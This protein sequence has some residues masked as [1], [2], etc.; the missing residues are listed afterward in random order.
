MDKYNVENQNLLK[1]P[2]ILSY[3]Y[4]KIL[5]QVY[6]YPCMNSFK[7]GDV[8]DLRNKIVSEGYLR[9]TP[10]IICLNYYGFYSN[11]QPEELLLNSYGW[12]SWYYLLIS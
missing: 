3:I 6:F 8:I 11:L 5:R 9:H 10:Y 7:M 12:L 1:K 4:Y 2:Y